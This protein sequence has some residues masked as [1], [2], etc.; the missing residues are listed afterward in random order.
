MADRKKIMKRMREHYGAVADLGYE[1]VGLF[2][3]GS[4]NY[5]L[6]YEGSDIDTKCIVLPKFK[7]FVHSKKTVSYTH[8]MENNE[9]VD[10]KD[11]REMFDCFKKQNSN[12]LE[13]LFTDYMIIN[14]KYIP[15]VQELLGMKESIA[16]YDEQKFLNACLGMALQK[17]KAMCHPYPA[18]KDKIE[19]YG[20]DGKQ[21]SHILR[22]CDLVFKYC[23]G[24]SFSKCLEPINHKEIMDYKLNKIP[25]D[26]AEYEA[27]I[28]IKRIKYLKDDYILNTNPHANKEVVEKM[29]DILFRILE[30]WFKEELNCN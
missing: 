1:I 17:Q 27:E 10:I 12:F 18:T 15:I 7:D 29:D 26:I 21:V 20:F 2:L 6:D 4:Q 9:H 24:E 22:M 3:Q 13:I 16:R 25:L 8:V 11:I 23:N 14:D 30:Q 5:C 28:F 19:K